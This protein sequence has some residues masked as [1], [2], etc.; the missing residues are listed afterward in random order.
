MTFRDLEKSAAHDQKARPHGQPSV[1]VTEVPASPLERSDPPPPDGGTTAWL[2]VVSATLINAVAWGYPSAYGVF[3]LYYTDTLQLPSAQISWI[4][5]VQTFLTYMMCTVAGRLAD[6]GYIRGTTI[7][8]IFLAMFGSFMTSFCT[9]YWQ[10]FLAQGLCTGVGLGLTYMPSLAVLSSYFGKKRSLAMAISAVGTSVG[11]AVFPAVVQYLVPQVGFPWAVRCCT[12]V[13]LVIDVVA[14]LLL[15]PRLAPRKTGPLVEWGAFKEP[16]YVLY[17]TGSFLIFWA[18]YFGF[19]YVSGD[20]P[21][22][23]VSPP[24]LTSSR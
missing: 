24:P 23:P 10:I 8:G 1:L 17:A 19:F 21:S 9:E 6:A 7:A 11:G 2:Q 12:L 4:G 20:P 14:L 15:K 16:P 22:P 18:L 3:Q 5:S 13:A